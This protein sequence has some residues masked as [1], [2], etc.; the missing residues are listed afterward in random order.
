MEPS[1]EVYQPSLLYARAGW[2]AV[3]GAAV[4]I[5]CGLRA[6]L[7]FIP[8]GLCALTA[9]LLFWLS[10]RAIIRV[11]E[12]Q[13]NIGDRAIAWREVREINSTKFVS[14]L[15]LSVKLTNSRRKL[16]IYPGEPGRIAHLI[17]QLR[18]N[19]HLATFD[20]VAYRDFWTWASLTGL[21]GDAPV[22]EQ[23][24]RM[25][26]HDEEDEI[27]RMYQTLKTVGRLDT[28]ADSSTTSH[29]D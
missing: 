6:P 10:A 20:G 17:A 16:L 12:T 26:S 19:A 2:I 28:H 9:V 1:V 18:K 23:P 4:C 15:V 22:L 29:E 11:G 13:F 8:G 27:E 24:V 3:S 21:P 7:A 14:P 25:L 5:L